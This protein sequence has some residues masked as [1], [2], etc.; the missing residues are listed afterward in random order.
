[1][2]L[3]YELLINKFGQDLIQKDEVLQVF[4][5]QNDE[6][7]ES[8]LVGLLQLIQ[9][10]KPQDFDIETI[11]L[12]SKLKPTYTPCV[13][14]R[15][16]VALHNLQKIIRLPVNERKKS[17]ILLL[18]TFRVAYQRRF[19]IECNDPN[20]WWYWDLSN[21]SVVEKIKSTYK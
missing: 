4:D 18:Y 3:E 6:G 10:S 2:E 12:A 17:L 16:G 15:Q 19:K 11:I 21:E 13:L 14:L 5:H 9:Q 8:F 20:K 7:K 1:M